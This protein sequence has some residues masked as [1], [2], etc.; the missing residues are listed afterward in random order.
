LTGEFIYSRSIACLHESV[1]KRVNIQWTISSFIF[2]DTSNA[3]LRGMEPTNSL[4]LIH[5]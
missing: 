5:Y 1:Y 4:I 3:R 2:S